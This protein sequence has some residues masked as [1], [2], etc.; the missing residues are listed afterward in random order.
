MTFRWIKEQI[1]REYHVICDGKTNRPSYKGLSDV[2]EEIKGNYY[3]TIRQTV[4]FMTSL[5]HVHITKVRES[6]HTKD[7]AYECYDKLLI[8]ILKRIKTMNH[9]FNEV[10][11]LQ[12]MLSVEN[13]DFPL[14]KCTLSVSYPTIRRMKRLIEL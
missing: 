9:P 6:A 10:S 8:I 14:P 13:E 5:R 12:S 1:C 4:R 3:D 2:H 11:H 7:K